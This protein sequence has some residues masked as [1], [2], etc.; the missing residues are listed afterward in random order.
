MRLEAA[1]ILE[2]DGFGEERQQHDFTADMRYVGQSFT[3]G[4]ALD[5]DAP[6]CDHLRA[7]FARRHEE[8]FGHAD[9]QS[10]VEIVNIRLV[11]RGLVDKPTLSFQKEEEG[12]PLIETRQVWFDDAW[13]DCPVLIRTRMEVGKLFLGP[14]II[15]EAGGTSVVPP[16]WKI[17]VHESG[18]LICSNPVANSSA[19][20]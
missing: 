14:A 20:A 18:S 19:G 5:A 1:A 6:D 8:T 10:D 13:C 11:S 12:D 16:G 15:E 9:A 17:F 3:L 4:V 2:R 7:G